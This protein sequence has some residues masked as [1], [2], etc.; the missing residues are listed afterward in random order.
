MKLDAKSVLAPAAILF[1]ICIVVAA[2]L[3]GRICP[4]I[5][6]SQLDNSTQWGYLTRRGKGKVVPPLA[7][8]TAL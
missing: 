5:L 6:K 3:A 8:V 1:A 4:P 2:A 7:A